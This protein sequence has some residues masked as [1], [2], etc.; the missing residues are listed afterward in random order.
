[1]RSLTKHLVLATAI[2]AFFA[3]YG[4][5]CAAEETA[6][7]LTA[8]AAQILDEFPA[9][10]GAH[11][12]AAEKLRRALALD[13]GYAKAYVQVGRLQ[14]AGGPE[15]GRQFAGVSAE[16]ASRAIM[17]A[18]ELDPADGQAWVLQAHLLIDMHQPA[19]AKYALIEAEKRGADSAWLALN[20]AEVYE[21]QGNI[22]AAMEK[23][24]SVVANSAAKKAALNHALQEL[25]VYYAAHH[26]WDRA[27]ETFLKA[28]AINPR[29]AWLRLRYADTLL[30]HGE[31]EK[32]IRYARETLQIK[33]YAAARRVLAVALY[34]R[35][36]IDV[37][38]QENRARAQT[39]Y[40][41]AQALLPDLDAVAVEASRYSGTRIIAEALIRE[42]L[43]AKMRVFRRLD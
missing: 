13:S 34:G 15:F 42:G 43:V 16:S 38:R 11:N 21:D 32:A 29:G 35:W 28:I 22:E 1:M 25:T 23:Y 7:A 27:D 6:A 2:T 5:A 8:D 39:S 24:R 12:A 31:F 19:D 3:G 41:E 9:A 37:S 17:K 30:A 33:D 20:W 40:D 26:D 4:F 18:L 36:A 14:I 10:D